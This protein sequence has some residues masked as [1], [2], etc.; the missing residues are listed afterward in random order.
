MSITITLPDDLV[1]KLKSRADNQNLPL[2]DLA[3]NIL[4]AALESDAEAN[5]DPTP[6]E[7]V[8]QIKAIPPNPAAIRPATGSLA[9]ALQ[10]APRDPDFDLDAWTKQWA[11]VEAEMKAITQANDMAEGRGHS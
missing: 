2:A 7:V 9:E 8:A 11:A 4:T 3:I 5:D 1:T 10:N 6:E